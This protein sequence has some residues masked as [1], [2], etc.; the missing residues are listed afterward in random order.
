[1]NR[2]VT[3]W[4]AL[5]VSLLSVS[6]LLAVPPSAA[7][8]LGGRVVL[9]SSEG[10]QYLMTEDFNGDGLPDLA[11]V[12]RSG[13]SLAVYV[14]EGGGEY[15]QVDLYAAGDGPRGLAAGDFDG[16][17][18]LD[19]V[20]SN[21]N[22]D[23]VAIFAGIGDG[24]FRV[25]VFISVGDAPRGIA[26]GELT[27]DGHI[28]MAV[29]IFGEA[30]IVILPGLGDGTF[31]EPVAIPLT[32]NPYILR[33]TDFT[34]DG[35]DDLL[36]MAAAVGGHFEILTGDGLGGF[37]ASGRI[38]GG[39]NFVTG[40]FN[41]GSE[42][43]AV[44]FSANPNHGVVTYFGDGSGG[45]MQDKIY[46]TDRFP[47]TGALADFN[48][49]GEL[50]IVLATRGDFTVSL[51]MG[52]NDGKFGSYAAYDAA[53]QA[54]YVVAPDL[55]GDGW[56]DVAVAALGT[57]VS[58]LFNQRAGEPAN[59]APVANAGA[60]LS[61][62]DLDLS[63]DETVTLDASASTDADGS[64]VSWEWSWDY[65]NGSASG[66]TVEAVFPIG[67]TPVSLTVTDNLGVA[68]TDR[69]DVEVI[70]GN[71][72]P[73]AVAGGDQLLTDHDLDGIELATLD[74]SGS[75]DPDGE[76][77]I[78][79]WEWSW[80]GGSAS[81]EV[82]EAP[83]PTG[84]NMVTLTVTDSVGI[85]SVDTLIVDVALNG[86][87]YYLNGSAT[88][89]ESQAAAFVVADLNDDGQPDFVVT[90]RDA[91]TLVVRFGALDGSFEEATTIAAGISPDFLVKGYF[92]DDAVLD[93]VVAASGGDEFRLFKGLG[94]G[95]F[96]PD[97]SI[98][99]SN[100]QIYAMVTVDVN[101]DGWDD[102]IFDGNGRIEVYLADG[103]G[104][105]VA[106]PGLNTGRSMSRM[107][108]TDFNGDGYPDIAYG[109]L[110]VDVITLHY[111]DGD[112]RFGEG[113]DVAPGV[114]HSAIVAGD[115]NGDGKADLASLD[116]LDRT[117]RVLLQKADGDFAQ[118]RVFDASSGFGEI[119]SGDFNGD[120]LV[121]IVVAANNLNVYYGTGSGSFSAPVNVGRS[122]APGKLV[123]ADVNRDGVDDFF[124]LHAFPDEVQTYFIGQNFFLTR[125]FRL[126]DSPMRP[127]V[128]DINGDEWLDLLVVNELENSLGVLF[129]T[130]EGGFTLEQ[131]LLNN[132][133]F[134]EYA[135][136]DFTNDG[137]DD[138]IIP[139]FSSRRFNV[140]PGLGE[141]RFGELTT[142]SIS[143]EP[144]SVLLHDF[145]SDG[146]L[147]IL[148]SSSFLGGFI[149][150][151]D[152]S[153]GV[154]TMETLSAV[155]GNMAGAQFWDLNVDGV[156]DLV[157]ADYSNGVRVMLGLEDG[158]FADPVTYATGQGNEA[159]ALGDLNADGVPDVAVA[160]ITSGTEGFIAVLSGRGD[161]TFEDAVIYADEQISGL[162]I[163][164]FNGD[165]RDDVAT[166]RLTGSD[167]VGLLYQNSEG[168]L[169]APVFYR[170]DSIEAPR[171]L[172]V[173]DFD[174]D[175]APDIL[176]TGGFSAK[177]IGLLINQRDLP[178]ANAGKDIHTVD[179]DLSGTER[180][181]LDGS[182]S[183][184]A[185]GDLVQWVWSWDGGSVEGEFAEALL[186]TGVT[187]VTL[188]VTDFLG[189]LATDTLK[190]SVTDL[191]SD[192]DGLSNAFEQ[193]IIDADLNDAVVDFSDVNPLTDFNGDGISDGFAYALGL[194][195]IDPGDPGPL[196]P[197]EQVVVSANQI[198]VSMRQPLFL[199]PGAGL[200]LEMSASPAESASWQ[201]AAE[202]AAGSAG[203]VTSSGIDFE[204]LPE[205]SEVVFTIPISVGEYY[206]FRLLLQ[207][208][209]EFLD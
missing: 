121:D 183:F 184:R 203:W 177:A 54:S 124:V 11:G 13:D 22:S 171:E 86:A 152:G 30:K 102:L 141:G 3:L 167:A 73:V 187:V 79:S 72:A 51:L 94:G 24:T 147:D 134:R 55:N 137:I 160:G 133:G 19:L 208:S 159:F 158:G 120:G 180:V 52:D 185:D 16:D 57:G 182:G 181:A 168:T 176:A 154:D 136:G 32:V 197:L 66:E 146:A 119:T 149:L 4:G 151:N 59:M 128:V 50:D 189:A 25:P 53:L 117:L 78:V 76:D 105:F 14:A 143:R 65:G 190:V 108:A 191:D 41:G 36:L 71:F 156:L 206:Y 169:E 1:M 7:G 21:E 88:P 44:L 90:N 125:P 34:G 162:A 29:A 70:P 126:V 150:Y 196:F 5:G 104:G 155:S 38:T 116:S 201:M 200:R 56:P 2:F 75:T 85:Q 92:D 122:S 27:G 9:T 165:G 95:D 43:V 47:T 130:P 209:G 157:W 8:V 23:N 69:I 63:M 6:S 118:A 163:A 42:D 132:D 99:V 179:T 89:V 35:V 17:G 109:V 193:A 199:G 135:Y 112:G 170:S 115:F 204:T 45:V 139:Q 64:I 80:D 198:R 91:D 110:F 192:D 68:S 82:V 161:G 111:G 153:G 178:I 40:D 74:G 96:A 49:D 145:D 97:V 100:R 195:A 172:T 106:Q 202:W 131:T 186:P 83:F 188:T 127:K 87:V 140:Y 77:D 39:E 84:S 175:G 173:A 164:D 205:T 123:V 37:S 144:N 174:Q 60:D 148:S 138:I 67:V 101:N 10:L 98:P 142:L 207:L 33:A 58:L 93:L 31:G 103:T 28:D 166:A 15:G 48:R 107:V 81:G 113:I 46:P 26:V 194:S 20:V 114:Q 18:V 61:V 62:V 129:G 12:S